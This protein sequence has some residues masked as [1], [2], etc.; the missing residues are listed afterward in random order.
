MKAS[1]FVFV[2]SLTTSLGTLS[3]CS[4]G[5]GS[6]G[7]GN[8]T[9][10]NTQAQFID[11]PV[12]G[13]SYTGSVSGSGKTGDSGSFSCVRGE[14]LQFNLKGLDLGYAACGE[15]VFVADLVSHASGFTWQKAA[16][17]IQ[18]FSTKS[19]NDLDL[20][21]AGSSLLDLSSVAYADGTFDAT[22]ASKVSTVSGATA[23]A[24][25][26]AESNANN[27]MAASISLD[28][29]LESILLS[30]V[31]TD[32]TVKGTLSS[33]TS[34]PGYGEQCWP[35]V[36]AKGQITKGTHGGKDLYTFSISSP[37][38]YADESNTVGFTCGSNP[39]CVT[40]DPRV[41]PNKKV[42]YSSNLD[43]IYR[44]DLVSG[45][46]AI[47]GLGQTEVIGDVK[48]FASL[49]PALSAS[50]G[51]LALTGTY[52]TDIYIV[53]GSGSYALAN[54]RT[55]NCKYSMTITP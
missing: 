14:H 24:T 55:I 26:D 27:D 28:P 16:A 20:S 33:G 44:N 3:A 8:S 48:A 39:S 41:V 23:V 49:T 11:A 47:N 53:N 13:L 32:I 25:I 2:I 45:Y 31:S 22:V 9:A 30:L 7:S 51:Q 19:G 52:N 21:A 50:G 36:K 5:G 6:S 34:F 38:G 42:I 10:P 35:Y 17:V 12:K 54:G 4:G 46:N 37:I 15:K 29:T 1:K 43:L 40:I 18:S